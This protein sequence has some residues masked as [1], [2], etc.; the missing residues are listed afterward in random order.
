MSLCSP[1]ARPDQV[2]RADRVPGAGRDGHAEGT[3]G[4]AQ[5]GGPAGWTLHRPAGGD[6]PDDGG[7]GEIPPLQLGERAH[8][9]AA[10]G[11]EP[12]AHQA[13]GRAVRP[14]RA[15]HRR[16]RGEVGREHPEPGPH[17]A[18]PD[19]QVRHA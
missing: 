3:P 6:G 13:E 14:L 5:R 18:G 12:R 17:P 16:H 1:L 2:L 8:A 7:G 4:G 11:G 9:A 19:R 15:P 10:G